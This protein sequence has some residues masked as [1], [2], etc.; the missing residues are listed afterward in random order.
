MK[1]YLLYCIFT[2]LV[3]VNNTTQAQLRI[4]PK[5]WTLNQL[6][7]YFKIDGRVVEYQGKQ[8]ASIYPALNKPPKD[9]ITAF[10]QNY[11]RRF[12]YILQNKTQFLDLADWYPDTIRINE[13]YARRLEVNK[14]F[15]TYLDQL[16]SPINILP[17]GRQTTYRQDEL[18]MVASRFFLCDQVRPDTTISW[19]V[20]IGLN[21]VK[22]ARWKKDYTVLEAFCFE[23][24]FEKM[25]GGNPADVRYMDQFLKAIDESTR[26]R[27]P[28]MRDK[29]QLLE[30]VKL[31]VFEAMESDS[32]LKKCLLD[33]YYEHSTSLPFEIIEVGNSSKDI[34]IL[35]GVPGIPEKTGD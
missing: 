8:Y 27:R 35:N 24:V 26:K 4:N 1:K 25:F 19:H 32:A 5:R 3:M 30:L 10:M 22:E 7:E 12:E 6:K 11:H 2:S 15:L 17:K 18:M 13:A 28:S 34:P 14:P 33:Y 16:L 9:T 29:E 20:C 21:G 23:A 31:D